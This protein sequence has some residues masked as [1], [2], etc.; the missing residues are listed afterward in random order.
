[1]VTPDRVSPSRPRA[2]RIRRSWLIQGEEYA[3]HGVWA[4]GLIK[5]RQILSLPSKPSSPLRQDHFPGRYGMGE[6][7]KRLIYM[8]NAA[9]TWPK[10]PGVMEEVGRCLSLP[11][12]EEGRST[13]AD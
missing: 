10:P 5:G 8:N 9:T 4:R 7:P 13:L 3:I 12:F 6:A 11:F 2:G 1:M